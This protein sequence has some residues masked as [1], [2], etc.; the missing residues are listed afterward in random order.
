MKPKINKN[1]SLH[2]ILQK[3]D[4]SFNKKI[5]KDIIIS[6]ISDL[7]TSKKN[8]IGFFSNKKYLK[9]LHKTKLSAILIKK[10]DLKYLPKNIVYIECNNPE[11]EFIKILCFF[12]PD[13]ILFKNFLLLFRPIR[14]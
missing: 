7:V 8:S 10:D 4:I 3:C 12:Y 9:S 2:F 14:N 11:L 13:L 5:V 6:N 1:Y